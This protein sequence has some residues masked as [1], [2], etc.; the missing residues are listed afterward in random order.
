MS[1]KIVLGFGNN[2]DYEIVWDIDQI[3]TLKSNY[4]FNKE[5]YILDKNIT[6]IKSILSILFLNIKNNSGGEYFVDNINII[7]EFVK[8][9]AFKTT[10]GGTAL[11]S[12][13]ALDL[14]GVKATLHVV[15]NNNIIKNFIPKNCQYILSNDN[16]KNYPHLIIQYPSNLKIN[17]DNKTII[18]KKP[19]RLIFVHDPHNEQLKINIK[20]KKHICNS[21][22]F[23]ISGFNS[24]KCLKILNEKISFLEDCLK[25]MS[26]KSY[27]FYEDGCY[28]YEEV[29]KVV[30][31]FTYNNAYI[32]SMNED[33]FLY[34]TRNLKF[35]NNPNVLLK[36]LM[37][38]YETYKTKLLVIHTSNWSL[39]YGENARKYKECLENAILIATGRMIHGDNLKRSNLKNI[40]KEFTYNKKSNEFSYIVNKK[41]GNMVYC[42]PSYNINIKNQTTIGLGDFFVGGFL[43][44]LVNKVF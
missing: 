27:S 32:C 4:E 36:Q 12:A 10:A 11:R 7:N 39:V 3:N 15:T 38:F 31:E 40:N 44:K 6:S 13:I 41:G 8:N 33:E 34:F 37:N 29:S 5:D 28:H 22:I 19:D 1:A 21:K 25:S 24:I 42:L 20:I 17:I 18:T 2:I 16:T 30:R 26:N 43:A 14:Q 23:L 9:F 35:K